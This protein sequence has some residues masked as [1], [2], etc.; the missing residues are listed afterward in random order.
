[1]KMNL[2]N[3]LSIIRICSVPVIT[4][5]S[6]KDGVFDAKFA[7]CMTLLGQNLRKRRKGSYLK[8]VCGE[9]ESCD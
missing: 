3:K 5:Q 8:S 7:Q 6:G 4:L 1:M 9:G 2:P